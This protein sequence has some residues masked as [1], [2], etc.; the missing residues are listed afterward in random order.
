[1]L[2]LSMYAYE[3]LGYYGEQY[4]IEEIGLMTIIN[5]RYRNIDKKEFKESF[6]TAYEKSMIVKSS[7]NSCQKDNT[8]EYDPTIILDEDINIPFYADKTLYKKGYKYNILKENNLAF[9]KY[10]IFINADDDLQLQLAAQLQNRADI[11]VAKGDISKLKKYNISGKISR[12]N[13]ESKAF[14]LHCLPSIYAQQ[15]NKFIVKEYDIKKL[16]K[17]EKQ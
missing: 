2:P 14:K 17:S 15:N 8:R 7:F 12:E 5:E 6:K 1:M 11:Y 9:M 4:E 10:I 13:V 3:D 16:A